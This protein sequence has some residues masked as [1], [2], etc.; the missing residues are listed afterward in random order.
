MPPTRVALI[1]D[2]HLDPSAPDTQALAVRYLETA[3]DDV[4]ALY[5][6]GDLFEAWVGDDDTVDWA[7]PFLNALAA[8]SARGVAVTLM[9]GNRDFLLGEDFAGRVGATLDRADTAVVELGAHRALVM[10]GDTLC[11]DDTDYLAVRAAVRTP[12]W[13]RA[14]LAQPLADRQ[15]QAKALRAESRAKTAAKQLAL[16]DAH[17]AACAAALREHRA[18]WLVHGHTHRPGTHRCGDG[19]RHVLGEWL[20]GGATVALLDDHGVRLA[21]WPPGPS[22]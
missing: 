7:A 18:D 1:S 2:L 14:F 15:A 19:T 16:T 12:E 11:T 20:P 8:V 6:L 21:H 22:P 3:L 4:T 9:H 17:P 5:I 13:Q 10:H